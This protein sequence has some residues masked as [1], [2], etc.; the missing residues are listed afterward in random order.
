MNGGIN[1][2]GRRGGCHYASHPV[3]APIGTAS[4]IVM[5]EEPHIRM[6]KYSEWVHYEGI[7][8]DVFERLLAVLPESG[9]RVFPAPAGGDVQALRQ[10]APDTAAQA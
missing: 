7:Q 6:V 3:L 9:R 1:G 8:L 4:G 10:R 2:N 5:W